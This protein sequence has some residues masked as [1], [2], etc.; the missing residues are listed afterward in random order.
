M[1][2]PGGLQSVGL[3]RI[4]NEGSNISQA[5]HVSGIEQDA[6]TGDILVLT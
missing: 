6:D 4:G 2:K 5:H 3:Q 1:E